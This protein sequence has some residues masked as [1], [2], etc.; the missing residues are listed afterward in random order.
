MRAARTGQDHRPP[1][2][3]TDGHGHVGWHA[4]IPDQNPSAQALAK[5][6][7]AVALIER[8]GQSYEIR[9]RT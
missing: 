7:R 4:E 5:L 2:V 8:I 1:R 6:F 3:D 9:V